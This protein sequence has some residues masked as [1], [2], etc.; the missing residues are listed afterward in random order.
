MGDETGEDTRVLAAAR[1]LFAGLGYDGTTTEMIA[2]AAGVPPSAVEGGKAELYRAILEDFYTAQMKMFDEVEAGY[3]G[4]EGDLHRAVDMLLDFYL[5]HPEELAVWL[6]R[7]LLDAVDVADVDERFRRP[8][9]RRLFEIFDMLESIP[10]PE[11]WIS[12]F[13]WC[14][15]GFLNGGIV[16]RDTDPLTV[17]DPAARLRF[18]AFMHRLTTCISLRAL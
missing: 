1:R 2:T 13:S 5:D 14:I 10:D 18:R 3:K 9:A 4:G 17:D 12:A 16:A 7:G 6:Y 11:T 15:T 8:L